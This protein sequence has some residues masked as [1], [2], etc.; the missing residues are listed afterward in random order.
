MIAKKACYKIKTINDLENK[1]NILVTNKD[2][3][4]NMKINAYNHSQKQFF[5]KKIFLKQSTNN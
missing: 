4:H 3:M 2:M 5:N 1:I